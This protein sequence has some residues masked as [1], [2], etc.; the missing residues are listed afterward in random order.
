MID[1]YM[2]VMSA[3]ADVAGAPV[4]VRVVYRPRQ[5]SFARR[6]LQ[7]GVGAIETFSK[8]FVP[9]PWS[10]MTVIDPPPEA[11]GA[12][13]MEYPT[14]VTSGADNVLMRPGIR[15][16]EFVTV[17]EIG[18]NWF[19]G[20][21]ASNE[22]R[23]AWLD[24]G[25]NEW[26]D[27]LVMASLYGEKQSAI[28]WDGWKAEDLRLR[29]AIDPDLGALPSAIA[30]TAATFPDSAAYASA[31]YTKTAVALRT[32]AQAV[33]DHEQPRFVAAMRRYATDW[34]FRHPTGADLWAS[35]EATL[36]EDLDWFVQPAFQHPGGVDFAVRT[37]ELPAQP[38]AARRLRRGLGPAHRGR[39]PQ[40]D[41]RRLP[42]P[43]GDREPRHDP[44]AGDDRGALPGRHPRAPHLEPP[45][46]Q[47]LAGVRGRAVVADRAGDDRSRRPGAA[48]R[49]SPRRS[50]PHRR[51]SP[52][53]VAGHRA[54]HGVDPGAHAGGGAVTVG[55]IRLGDMLRAGGRAVSQYTGTVLAVYLVQLV[56]AGIAGFAILSVLSNAFSDRMLFDQAVDGDL[57]SLLIDD[58]QRAGGGRRGDVDRARRGGRV[59]GVEL[60][61]HRRRAGGVDRAAPGPARHRALLRRRRRVARS[62]CSRAWAWCRC[63]LQPSR[64]WS[65]CRMGVGY[66]AE[67]IAT[68]ITV[69]ELIG[70]LGL[71]L[72][73][74][75]LLHVLA[76]TCD[77]LRAGRADLAPADPRHARRAARGDPRGGVPGAA[78]GGAA[79]RRRVLARLRAGVAAVSLWLAKDRA[80]LGTSGALALFAI[81]QAVTLVRTALKFALLAGQVE[82][83]GTRPPPPRTVARVET[84]DR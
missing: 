63:L 39:R 59:D 5:R 15:V 23:E 53:D 73:P 51:R 48:G 16:P 66:L 22:A 38:P 60:V 56:A 7:A 14:L 1:P 45:R 84:R 64:R 76:S 41:H 83:T 17:H 32:L 4:E 9:Y 78:A 3:T 35:L 25:V 57:V 46:Q 21:L 68:A 52:R 36:G 44:G 26:A 65:R 55:R 72:G 37:A 43:G 62:W 61:L 10:I 42:V 70:P 18:H 69:G 31:T 6:H 79:P 2:Q 75:A 8:L 19:Q 20:I 82:L 29:R 71:G 28:D 58:P 74:A 11:M 30:S 77:R 40:P 49:S 50:R 67:R 80:M 34:A 12:G 47:P 24:E 81:R 27:A 33:I 54:G 13:G